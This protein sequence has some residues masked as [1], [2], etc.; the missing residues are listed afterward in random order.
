MMGVMWTITVAHVGVLV[1]MLLP[2]EI[3][4]TLRLFMEQ[5]GWAT[6]LILTTGNRPD[7]WLLVMHLSALFWTGLL[8]W[9]WKH[10]HP[11]LKLG[12]VAAGLAN[13][14]IAPLGFVPGLVFLWLSRRPD[15]AQGSA[16]M[17]VL[18]GRTRT[19]LMLQ[20]LGATIVFAIASVAVFTLFEML[21]LAWM[22]AQ[23]ILGA[24]LA[25][26]LWAA[27][28]T[29]NK[30]PEEVTHFMPPLPDMSRQ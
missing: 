13:L 20:W 23:L 18:A 15:L 30:R 7:E 22:P 29:R 26:P 5:G 6:G 25:L 12:F 27:L 10:D 28:S 19:R 8:L 2:F 16:T 17:R 24:I 21:F 14:G 1:T 4:I 9:L 11:R 3:G